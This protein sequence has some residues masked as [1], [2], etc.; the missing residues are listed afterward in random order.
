MGGRAILSKA[1]LQAHRTTVPGVKDAVWNPL[2]DTQL[3]VGTTGHTQL[4][5]FQNPVGTGTTSSPGATGAKTDGDTN[6]QNSGM[7][8][9]GNEFYCEGIELLFFPG[10]LPM[11]EAVA[12]ANVGQFADDVWTFM[13]SGWLRFKI[14]QRDYALDAPLGKFPPTSRLQV[15]SATQ[16]V[17]A[18]AATATSTLYENTYASCAGARYD[19]V[20]TYIYSNQAFNVQLN[21]PI[22]VTLPSGTDARLQVRL[23]GYL[24]RDAQ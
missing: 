12:L 4:N 9:V 11:R 20:P 23:R 15:V 21:W 10:I 3:Y 6:M 13:R 17:P 24:I 14:Q 19:I 8:A 22:A 16:V 7:L 1:Q 18:G 5:F 2:Y